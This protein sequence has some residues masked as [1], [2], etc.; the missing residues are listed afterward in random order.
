[1]GALKVRKIGNSVGVVLPKDVASKLRVEPGDQL[2]VTETPN[3]VE[4][5][6]Y[7]PEFEADMDLARDIMRKRRAVLRELAK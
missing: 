1:M 6:P 7:D 3:G 4:L 2:F 5:S